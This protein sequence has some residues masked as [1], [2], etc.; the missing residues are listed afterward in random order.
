MPILQL[1]EFEQALAVT[2]GRL[3]AGAL[4]ECHGAVCG[5]LCRNPGHG[6][7]Q[8]LRLLAE[9]ELVRAPGADV[10]ELLVSLHGATANQIAD[11]Q[12]RF[13]LWLPGDE[14]PLE[15]RTRALAHWCNGFL[16]GLGFGHDAA[17]DNLSADMEG[18]LADLQQIALADIGPDGEGEDEETALTEIIEYIRVVTLM[19]REELRPAAPRD[20]VH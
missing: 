9:L 10:R 6:G 20:S 3:D 14:E 11:A 12:M 7:D 18:V 1:P 16:A 19:L 15:D 17:L 4:S 13:S 8:Y 5:M 2:S